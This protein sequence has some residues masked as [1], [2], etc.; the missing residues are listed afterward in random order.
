MERNTLP[1]QQAR[2]TAVLLAAAWLMQDRQAASDLLPNDLCQHS[3]RKRQQPPVLPGKAK[4][5]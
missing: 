3:E 4:L 2:R 1:Q 5:N